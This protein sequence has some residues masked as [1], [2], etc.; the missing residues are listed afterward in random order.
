MKMAVYFDEIGIFT[1]AGRVLL[2]TINEIRQDVHAVALRQHVMNEKLPKISECV[3][4]PSEYK[5][6]THNN[7]FLD[8]ME[9]CSF[10]RKSI[11]E[12]VKKFS[13]TP[14][15]RSTDLDYT[16]RWGQQSE[17]ASYKPLQEHLLQFGIYT[18]IVGEGQ[19]LP[20]GI[21]YHQELWTLKKNTLLR[22]EDLRKKAKHLSSSTSCEDALTS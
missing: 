19:G 4:N 1:V 18:E 17:N 22:S 20:D 7:T 5:K 13:G 16:F 12:Q 3:I 10:F 14:P 8:V 6:S 15:L 21:L 11:K 2:E 9:I